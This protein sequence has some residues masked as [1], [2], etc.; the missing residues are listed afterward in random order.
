[1]HGTIIII[2]DYVKPQ[3]RTN[4][5]IVCYMELI[6]EIRIKKK[7]KI[8]SQ[9]LVQPDS[10]QKDNMLKMLNSVITLSRYL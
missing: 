3:I 6:C 5:K 7:T 1:M 9:E 2:H 10:R 4:K 8:S